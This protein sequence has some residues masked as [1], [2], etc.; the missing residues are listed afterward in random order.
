MDNTK[1]TLLWLDDRRDPF[2]HENWL[3]FSPIEKPFEVVWL[4]TYKRFIKW[5]KKNGL[6]DAICF[7]HDL[8]DFEID[9]WGYFKS[10]SSLYKEKTGYDCAEWLVNYCIDNNLSLPK[11]NVQ[12]SNIPGKENINGI[13]LSYLKFIENQK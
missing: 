5:I 8:S 7:D 3:E 11:W 6:P 4:K 13:L 12:S 2:R 10:H 1:K 9:L